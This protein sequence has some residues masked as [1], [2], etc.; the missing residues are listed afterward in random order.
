MY[1][2]VHHIEG[3]WRTFATHFKDE[4]RRIAERTITRKDM[5]QR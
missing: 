4:L 1:G 3:N 5:R 2:T